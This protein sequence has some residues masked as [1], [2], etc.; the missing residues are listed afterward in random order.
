MTPATATVSV[1]MT[2]P[3]VSESPTDIL[4]QLGISSHLADRSDKSL[5]TAY[6]KYRSHLEAT[7]TYQRM[8]ADNTWV[9]SKLTSLDLIELF[10]SKSFYFSHYKHFKNVSA[11]PDLV[12]WLENTS[13]DRASDVD[14]WGYQK[15]SY[16]WQDLKEYLDERKD[17][18]KGKEKA[19]GKDKEKVKEK[20]A[21]HKKKSGNK[22]QVK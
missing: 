11:Y 18:G 1:Q 4:G 6:Q 14:V 17:K 2:K 21:D 22:K 13:E 10:I 5:H 15:A 9:G 3:S 8:L 12:E 19:K 16:T 7:Q 20:K